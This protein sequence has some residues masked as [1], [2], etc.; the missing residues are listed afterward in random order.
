MK[1]AIDRFVNNREGQEME[2]SA[3]DIYEQC[4]GGK[5]LR[6][7]TRFYCPECH[8]RVFWRCRSSS[9]RLP[10]VFSHYAKTDSS[11]ECDKRVDGHSDLY[12]YERTG[13]PLYLS[14]K[15]GDVYSLNIAFPAIGEHLLRIASENNVAIKI[16]DSMD[17]KVTQSRF[18]SDETTLIPVAFLPPHEKN[19]RISISAPTSLI[20]L[21]KKWSDYADGFASGGAIFNIQS[22]GGKKI[23]RGDSIT[24]GKEYYAVAKDLIPR[25]W[26]SKP[27]YPEIKHRVVGKIAL[28]NTTY[29]VY[30]FSVDVSAD[31][32]RFETL[33]TFFYNHFKVWLVEQTATIVPIWPP[34]IERGDW[35]S[36]SPRG[37]V[38]CSVESGNDSPK[39]FTYTGSNA[40]D[41]PVRTDANGNNSVK[42]NI[43]SNDPTMVS[44]DRKYTGREVGIRKAT[45]PVVAT[46][47]TVKF[48]VAATEIIRDEPIDYE[49]ISSG[50][51]VKSNT[52]FT[53]LQKSKKHIYRTVA[54][55]QPSVSIDIPNDTDELIM[56]YG[57]TG[58]GF[59]PFESVPVT[60][61]QKSTVFDE[62]II[63]TQI[64]S[65]AKGDMILAPM[66]IREVIS[67]CSQN[68][69][70]KIQ[71]SITASICNGRIKKGLV[72]YLNQFRRTFIN[73]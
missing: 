29:N 3:A 59:V 24:I 66:W 43:Y 26:Y 23:K 55:D 38:Y 54:I 52:K 14:L 10:D 8:E 71:Q 73:G 35:I 32:S 34:I 27:L 69:Y 33:N 63:V 46:G 18:F 60:Y 12:I 58:V 64:Q 25:T 4:H 57:R 31:S 41:V 7:D 1:F 67:F 13:L 16:N 56:A 49:S 22:S 48:F 68:Q 40:L 50:I 61:P 72:M 44:V 28:N 20:G 2:V 9:G 51:S 30:V 42:F 37:Q 11:P 6:A 45:P 21:R 36:F 70:Y 39:V 47:H 17:V 65:Y 15:Y 5:P 62:S 19:Y 53:L